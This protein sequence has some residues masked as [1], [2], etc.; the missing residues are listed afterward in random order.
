M[1]KTHLHAYIW[2]NAVYL[3]FDVMRLS[4]DSSPNASFRNY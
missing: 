1:D 2:K 4:Y 3:Q